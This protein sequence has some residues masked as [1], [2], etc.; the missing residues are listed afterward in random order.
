MQPADHIWKRHNLNL[1]CHHPCDRHSPLLNRIYVG[2]NNLPEDLVTL[3]DYE[4]LT[5]QLVIHF[6]NNCVVSNCLLRIQF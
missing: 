4:M 5:S 6:N 1:V 2:N 3:P